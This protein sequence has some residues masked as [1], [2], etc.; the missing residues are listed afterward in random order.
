LSIGV[1]ISDVKHDKRRENNFYINIKKRDYVKRFIEIIKSELWK[2]K[3][4]YL[5]IILINF[6]NTNIS[7]KI[8]VEVKE[9]WKK[10]REKKYL[11]YTKK[12]EVFLKNACIK[13][14][15]A[16]DRTSVNKIIDIIVL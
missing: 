6:S 7:E 15:L 4:Y 9:F 5:A 11:T 13:Y 16:I 14:G 1:D 8:E 12:F 2:H 10:R 3:R